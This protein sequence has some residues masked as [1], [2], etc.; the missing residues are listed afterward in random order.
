M[1]VQDGNENKPYS[2]FIDIDFLADIKHGLHDSNVII[3]SPLL[4]EK[5]VDKIRF[6]SLSMSHEANWTT[7]LIVH[8]SKPIEARW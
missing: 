7:S 6:P 3:D 8:R 2:T 4:I 1:T 5:V